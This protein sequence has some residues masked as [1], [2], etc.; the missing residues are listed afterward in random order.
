[1]HSYTIIFTHA[2]G[3]KRYWMSETDIRANGFY[4]HELTEAPV[5]MYMSLEEAKQLF[6]WLKTVP[7]IE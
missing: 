4:M 2:S 6:K 1:M 5:E 7:G 3:R